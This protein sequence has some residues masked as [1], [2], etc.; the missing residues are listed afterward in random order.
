MNEPRK[1]RF[2]LATESGQATV[3]F[4]ILLVPLLVLIL[5]MVDFGVAFQRK[6]KMTQVA[7]SAARYAAVGVNPGSGSFVQ[8]VQDQVGAGSPTVCVK[9]PSTSPK[10]GDTV[11]VQITSNY[12]FVPL[13]GQYLASATKTITTTSSMRI[14]RVPTSS[15]ISFSTSC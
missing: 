7:S 8:Y 9:A 6:I 5:G 3:E 14:E 4:A 10:A 12:N 13:V 2:H 11:T 1:H 15:P